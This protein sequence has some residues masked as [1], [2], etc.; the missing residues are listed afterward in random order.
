MKKKD[1]PGIDFV[2]IN[3]DEIRLLVT[4][5][6][7]PRIFSLEFRDSGN[8]FAELPNDY[9]EFTREKKFYFY[10][11][12]RL[13][14]SPENPSITYSPDDQPISINQGTEYVELSQQ[15][16]SITGMRK[17]I[18]IKKSACENTIIVDHT[19]KN[20]SD[21]EKKAAP[22]AITQLKLGGTA[23]LPFKKREEESNP[24]LPNRGIIL[25]PYTDFHDSRIYLDHDFVFVHSAPVKEDPLKIGVA[26][27]QQWMAY[28]I[29]N[30][31]FIK[32]SPDPGFDCSLDMGAARQCYC[33][34]KFLELETLG[35]YSN[36][37][38][39]EI[40]THREVWRLLEMPVNDPTREDLLDFIKQ[41]D[42]I[43]ICQELL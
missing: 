12:H 27:N 13:W 18:R 22:W 38:P 36:F 20:E 17:E 24:L 30:V 3:F 43:G 34:G 15:T 31:L 8:I 4:Q 9:L 11:G 10:G 40:I 37:K 42:W 28:S 1:F 14:V 21:S 7:G 6:V 26:N 25:W 5:S 35:M 16:D 19:I 32:Y 41:D 39:G 29:G 33:N 2:E 23:I